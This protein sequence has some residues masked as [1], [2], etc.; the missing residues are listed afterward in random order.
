MKITSELIVFEVQDSVIT[1]DISGVKIPKHLFSIAKKF[2]AICLA[3]RDKFK[4]A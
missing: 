1:V 4:C 2:S 3:S